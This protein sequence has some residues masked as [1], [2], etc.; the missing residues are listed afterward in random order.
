MTASRTSDIDSS[1]DAV[2]VGAG[3]IGL[4]IGWRA[5][6]RGLRTLVLDASSPASG[7]TGVAAGMLAPVSEA[8]FGEE[9]LIAANLEAARRYPA[10][11]AE[12]ERESR[13]D[14]H[15]RASGTL[16]VA[17]D[18]DDAELLRQLHGFQLSLGLE[19][20]WL[21]GQECRRLEPALAPGVVAG[22]RSSIDH[23][24]DPRRLARALVGA[25]EKASG[26]LRES[27][28][29]KH[30]SPRADSVLEVTLDSGETVEA[31]QVVIAAGWRSGTLDG[32]PER[33][34][35]PVRPVKGQ[36]LRLRGP[37]QAPLAGR[38]VRTPRVYIVPRDDGEVVVGATVEERGADT[39]VTAGGV[40]E[41]L[42][43]AYEALPGVTELELVETVAGLRPASPDNK[44]I[45]GRGGLPGFVW[46]TAHWRNGILL[47]PLTADAVAD[48]LT[49][50]ELP[51][52]LAPFGPDRFDRP[53][54]GRHTAP[55]GEGAASKSS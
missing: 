1:Y 51:E 23:Q 8:V 45:V 54:R 48:V 3:V 2:V 9:D 36:I 39:A 6:Q 37:R 34:R 16:A 17:L 19:A 40:L 32:L 12:V 31:D 13:L 26:E 50:A 30:V 41:L 10:F 53:R 7:A 44:P 22:I 35:V 20:E 28:R 55:V 46:A 5:A 33:V 14:T 25:L 38:V 43:E 49:G 27:C 29:V 18:R 4:S 47:A 52:P 15:Y 11:V 24:I 21:R 42:R